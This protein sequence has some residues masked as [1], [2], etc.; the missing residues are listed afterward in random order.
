MVKR[1]FFK[2]LLVASITILAFVSSNIFAE[3]YY[4]DSQSAV[5]N[6][7]LYNTN[8]GYEKENK[9]LKNDLHYGWNLGNFSIIGYSKVE[10]GKPPVFYKNTGDNL[11]LEFNLKQNIY[12]ID[13]N[14][15][16]FIIE[17]KK[18]QDTFFGTKVTDF[19]K[20]AMLIKY[21]SLDNKVSSP[22]I[23][24]DF[25]TGKSKNAK[26]MK[27]ELNEEGTYDVA[28]DYRLK[29]K[30]SFGTWDTERYR[31]YFSF[32]VINGKN[33]GYLFDIRTGNEITNNARVNKGF[34]IDLANSKSVDVE[35]KRQIWKNGTWDDKGI[36]AV[37]DGKEYT[38]KGKYIITFGNSSV[39]GKTK[40]VI[41]VKEKP[42]S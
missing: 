20:G 32:K 2:W 24:S 6:T 31:M 21:T 19:G 27:I 30:K 3:S 22:K 34:R 40:K 15:N 33:M 16:L 4:F 23:Y 36:E 28:L 38:K 29:K 35:V 17:D 25:L 26:D 42:H 8:Q 5:Q 18:G 13:N 37:S 1:N 11:V 39:S 12:S 14:K 7:T 41:Y 9:I 10:D